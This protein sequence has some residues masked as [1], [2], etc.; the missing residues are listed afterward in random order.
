M[1][2]IIKIGNTEF[3]LP[4][5]F[6][7]EDKFWYGLVIDSSRT[8]KTVCTFPFAIVPD[9]GKAQGEAIADALNQKYGGKEDE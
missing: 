4:F 8:P 3:E 7:F 6:V 1:S 5:R 9:K 2:K